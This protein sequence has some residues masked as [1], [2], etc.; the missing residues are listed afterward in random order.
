MAPASSAFNI[1]GEYSIEFI[2]LINL[3]VFLNFYNL[4]KK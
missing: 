2:N 4:T 1:D 3:G